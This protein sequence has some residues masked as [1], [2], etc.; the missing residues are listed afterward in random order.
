MKKDKA[1]EARKLLSNVEHW[2]AFWVNKGPI[3]RNIAEFGAKVGN[4]KPAQFAHHV[5][6]SKNDFAK[7]VDEAIGDKVLAKRLRSLKTKQ[8]IARV[9]SERVSAL[10]KLAK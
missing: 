1:N 2:K 7:W 3:Y 8:A 5:N 9:V 6:K 4:L 10:K